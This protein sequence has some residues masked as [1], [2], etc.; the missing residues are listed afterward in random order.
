MTLKSGEKNSQGLQD[1]RNETA[2]SHHW[3]WWQWGPVGKSE[4]PSITASSDKV[5]SPFPPSNEKEAK[6]VS[7]IIYRALLYNIPNIQGSI[8]NHSNQEPGREKRM[9][10]KR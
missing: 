9:N 2:L 4:G 8:E 10:F 7:L 3:H 1:P 6:T 5:T